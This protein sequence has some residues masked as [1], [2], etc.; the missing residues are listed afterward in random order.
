[1]MT[2]R[3]KKIAIKYLSKITYGTLSETGSSQIA[4]LARNPTLFP[5]FFIRPWERGCGKSG[6]K[7]GSNWLVMLLFSGGAMLHSWL[8]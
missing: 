1:M 8:I 7:L 3:R 4:E 2:P 5:G 6:T